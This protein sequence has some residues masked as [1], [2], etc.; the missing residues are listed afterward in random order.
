MATETPQEAI[1]AAKRASEAVHVHIF[2]LGHAAIGKWVAIRL[3]DGGSDGKLYDT[4][5]EAVRYQLHE[6]MCAYVCIPPGGMPPEDALVY[7]RVNRQLYDNGMRLADPD[8][9]VVVPTKF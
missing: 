2:A 9:H 8:K 3:A 6:N 5:A 1:D 4:K 7:L